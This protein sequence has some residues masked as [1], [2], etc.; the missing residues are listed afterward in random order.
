MM[1]TTNKSLT[2]IFII[3]TIDDILAL[4]F[5]LYKCSCLIRWIFK[6]CIMFE[7]KPPFN[8]YFLCEPSGIALISSRIPICVLPPPPFPPK[9]SGTFPFNFHIVNIKQLDMLHMPI[10]R[11]YVRLWYPTYKYN[12]YWIWLI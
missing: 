3:N 9:N 6:T 8:I 10:S 11:G 7:T 5:G 4:M 2:S 1:R 12:S